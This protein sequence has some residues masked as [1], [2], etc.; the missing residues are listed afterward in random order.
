MNFSERL[1]A[2]EDELQRIDIRAPQAGIVQQL[3]VHTAPGEAIMQIVPDRDALVVEVKLSP[4]DIDQVSIGQAVHPSK[5]EDV[6]PFSSG[7]MS[8]SA[9]AKAAGGI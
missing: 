9:L 5:T 7:M 1:V 6:I 3:A 4:T 8:A 2:A